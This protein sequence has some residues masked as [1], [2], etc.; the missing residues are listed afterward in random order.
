MRVLVV[1]AGSSSL[2]L[3]LLDHREVVAHEAVEVHAGSWDHAAVLQSLAAG[4]E[5]A[6]G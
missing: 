2:K 4:T 5:H 1:N 3:T 6:L